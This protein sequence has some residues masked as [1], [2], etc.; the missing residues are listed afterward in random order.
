[1]THGITNHSHPQELLR[2]KKII[3]SIHGILRTWIAHSYDHLG[4][5]QAVAVAKAEELCELVSPFC[6]AHANL[7][8]LLNALKR[9]PNDPSACLK[10]AHELETVSRYFDLDRYLLTRRA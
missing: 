9:L 6:P 4:F 3:Q 1:M 10:A 7:V 5:S 2:L 8:Q